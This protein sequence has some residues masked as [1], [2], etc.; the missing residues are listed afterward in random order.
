MNL[1]IAHALTRHVFRLSAHLRTAVLLLHEGVATAVTYEMRSGSPV[2]LKLVRNMRRML[3]PPV[4]R[5]RSAEAVLLGTVSA[6][7]CRRRATHC[8]S[9]SSSSSSSSCVL[10]VQCSAGDSGGDVVALCVWLGIGQ[11]FEVW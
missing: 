10:P 8:S 1:S 3:R 7:L 4:A 9:S 11:A 5:I 6:H 2:A